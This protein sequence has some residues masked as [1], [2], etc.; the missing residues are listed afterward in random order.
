MTLDEFQE[1]VRIRTLLPPDMINTYSEKQGAEYC[2]WALTEEAGEFA[3]NVK[4]MHRDD[5]GTLTEERKKR[6]LIELGDLFFYV[7]LTAILLNTTVEGVARMNMEKL[8]SRISR[9]V[10]GGSGDDR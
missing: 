4:K 6:L 1:E 5:G 10:L 2:A 8:D 3:S 7:N 9:G